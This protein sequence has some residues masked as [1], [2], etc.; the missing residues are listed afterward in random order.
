[1]TAGIS[2]FRIY[3]LNDC[4][5][6][7]KTIYGF[8]RE[9]SRHNDREW[10]HAHRDMYL[11]AKGEW[12]SLA[13][14]LVTAVAEFDPRAAALRPEDCLY[15][16]Y[17][18][19]RFSN[20]KRPYK[21]HVGI[22]VNPPRGKKGETLGYYFHLEPGAS[23]VAAGTAWLTPAL[24][25]RVRQSIY[26][27]I[28]EYVGIV[29]SPGFRQYFPSVGFDPLKTAPKGF[30]RN[31]EHIEYLKPRNFGAEMRV[32]DRWFDAEG[33]GARLRPVLAQAWLYNRFVNFAI[34]EEYD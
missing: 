23:L 29:E 5:M 20:D 34:E 9:L 13:A 22:F 4:I 33:L 28:E 26:D 16:I 24:L 11:A 12:E 25:K 32:D 19:T 15:R 1:M 10:F 21:T 7:T 6:D 27:N 31:W 30:D 3:P 8:L 2:V 18:D 14:M 17:R